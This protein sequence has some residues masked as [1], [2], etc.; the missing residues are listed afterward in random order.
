MVSVSVE[1]ADVERFHDSQGMMGEFGTGA[2]LARDG[3]TIL[4][5]PALFASEWQVRE[6]EEMLFHTAVA[7]QHPQA[8]VLPRSE[9]SSVRRRLGQSAVTHR[10][11]EI[12]C[13]GQPTEI[14][15]KNCVSDVMR[16]GDL[17][18]ADAIL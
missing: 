17:D 7:P 15:R 4:Q 9:S 13:A 16:T 3:S 12:A 6:Q 8:C 11:A 2:M 1:N 18:L 5:D 10:A 14:A